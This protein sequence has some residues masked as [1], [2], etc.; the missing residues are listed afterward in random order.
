MFVFPFNRVTSRALPCFL[1]D[2]MIMSTGH[3]EYTA[4][5]RQTLQ[6]EQ[7]IESIFPTQTA[8]SYRQGA[9]APVDAKGTTLTPEE[10]EAQ[11]KQQAQDKEEFFYIM[12]AVGGTLF[13]ITAIMVCTPLSPPTFLPLLTTSVVLH[14]LDDGRPL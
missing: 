12:L 2:M 8:A 4:L 14:R 13:V 9:P 1:T 3:N 5:T 6:I 10:Q 11:K 7:F